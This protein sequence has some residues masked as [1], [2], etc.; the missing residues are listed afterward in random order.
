L[1]ETK[2][3]LEAFRRMRFGVHTGCVPPFYG[4]FLHPIVHM[5][6]RAPSE[7]EKIILYKQ[8]H[9][10]ILEFCQKYRGNKFS[11]SE[12]LNST[13]EKR[14]TIQNWMLKTPAMLEWFLAP[15]AYHAPLA[16][17]KF[18][19]DSFGKIPAP[20]P[21]EF[22]CLSRGK[23]PTRVFHNKGTLYARAYCFGMSFPQMARITGEP[24][25]LIRDDV[26]EGITGLVGD[27]R[28]QLWCLNI[29]WKKV[30]WPIN[31][32]VG[33]LKKLKAQHALVK[34]P[35]SMPHDVVKLLTDSP[36]FWDFALKGTLPKRARYRQGLNRKWLGAHTHRRKKCQTVKFHGRQARVIKDP[37]E[38]AQS[39]ETG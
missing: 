31:L 3:G 17:P 9:A 13:A 30:Q 8:C 24:I 38:K 34:S 29:D 39:I 22:A 6:C 14:D 19:L 12:R 37:R 1:E 7:L 15:D 32:D 10:E 11:W 16:F 18:M 26:V 20:S 21:Y 4:P 27:P 23:I 36:Y 28:F 35:H 33:M 2:E 5:A 25:D